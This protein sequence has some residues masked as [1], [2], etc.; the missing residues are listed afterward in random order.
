MEGW[1]G[2]PQDLL[3]WITENAIFKATGQSLVGQFSDSAIPTTNVGLLIVGSTM[4]TWSAAKSKYV[5]LLTVP[6]GSVY[7]WPSQLQSPPDNHLFCEGQLLVITDY[8]DLYA[9]LGKIF[10]RPSDASTSF[11]MPNYLGRTGVGAGD[12]AGDYDPLRTGVGGGP[13]TQRVVGQY[14]GLE[15]P[16]YKVTAPAGQPTPRYTMVLGGS[17]RT[18]P[19]FVW[20]ANFY[21]TV[22][23]PAIGV[24]K[25]MRVQ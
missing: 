14:F 17:P 8:P 21:N 18:R 6:I 15:W 11:R 16:Q 20:A 13:I 24:R 7:D 22:V 5:P 4:F 3:T 10:N 9:V 2:S 23:P 12:T 1:Q 19:P 25:I